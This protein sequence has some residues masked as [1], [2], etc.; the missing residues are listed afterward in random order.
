MLCQLADA[1]ALKLCGVEVKL[2]AV[3]GEDGR[4]VLNQVEVDEKLHQT[5]VVFNILEL[6]LAQGVDLDFAVDAE[7]HSGLPHSFLRSH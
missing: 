2:E 5:F 4:L 6:D 1:N 3:D 7:Q